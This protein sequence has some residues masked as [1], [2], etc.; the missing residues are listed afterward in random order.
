MIRLHE[1]YQPSMYICST[2]FNYAGFRVAL[3]WGG[4]GGG[5]GGGR[6][7]GR[8]GVGTGGPTPPTPAR[9]YPYGGTL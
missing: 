9:G 1:L 3:G 8:K 5:G 7:E 4:G 2:N 6:A